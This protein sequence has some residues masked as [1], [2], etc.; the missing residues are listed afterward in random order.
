EH[1]RALGRVPLGF[2]GGREPDELLD[3]G[4]GEE[5]LGLPREEGDGPHG[6]VVLQRVERCEQVL[7]HHGRKLVDRLVLQVENGDGDAVVDELPGERRA[8]SH[9]RRSST[10]ASPIPPCAQIDS[11]PNYTSRRAISFES[12]VTSRVPV[13]PNGWPMAMEPPITLRSEEHT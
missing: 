5:V 6:G 12:V 13:A 7:F 2:R 3:V 4:A 8:R 9:Q 10:M 11:R 1:V